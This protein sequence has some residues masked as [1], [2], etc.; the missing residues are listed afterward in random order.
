MH[1]LHLHPSLF[2]PSQASAGNR[3][4]QKV[5]KERL[6][7]LCCIVS[8]GSLTDGKKKRKKKKP[9]SH[10]SDGRSIAGGFKY[11]K[12]KK[13]L[14]NCESLSQRIKNWV[15]GWSLSQLCVLADLFLF[16]KNPPE[17]L[18]PPPI[19]PSWW[20]IAILVLFRSQDA[21]KWNVRRD[22]HS[23]AEMMKTGEII[24]QLDWQLHFL[25]GIFFLADRSELS[26]QNSTPFDLILSQ[27]KL[28]YCR[29][30]VKCCTFRIYIFS[31]SQSDT[32][33]SINQLLVLLWCCQISAA[34]RCNAEEIHPIIR[35]WSGGGRF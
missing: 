35:F 13:N 23:Q 26:F 7:T 5:W 10:K 15:S 33:G 11:M 4:R 8:S 3:S 32:T 28:N 29:L 24:W 14:T 30:T 17:A 6:L 22:V 12:M 18:S 20:L 1:P 21:G 27:T 34:S 2:Y 16:S 9:Y 19:L 31:C 25:M